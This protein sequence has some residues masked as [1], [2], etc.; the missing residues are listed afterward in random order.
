MERELKFRRRVYPKWIADGRYTQEKADR[1]I[2]M[3]EAI[4][5]EYHTKAE[6]DEKAGRL[7]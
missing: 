4:R 6:A 5:G 3:F 7:I 1:E 2:A